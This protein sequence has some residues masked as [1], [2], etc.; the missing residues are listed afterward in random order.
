[1]NVVKIAG[2]FS[3]NIS[4][5]TSQAGKQYVGGTLSRSVKNQN[6]GEW[7]KEYF[8]FFPD[9]L[10]VI[11]EMFNQAK[12][13]YIKQNTNQIISRQQ[14]RSA[15]PQGGYQAP[16]GQTVKSEAEQFADDFD[17]EIPF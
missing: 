4:D 7:E 6:T 12:E 17:S 1:M 5:R 8:N 14:N 10:F 13:E 15:S 16:V 11:A 3:L 2:R 9:D